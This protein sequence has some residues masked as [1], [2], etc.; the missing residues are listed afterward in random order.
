MELSLHGHRYR[1]LI[2]IALFL[3]PLQGS[4]L[5]IPAANELRPDMALVAVYVAGFVLTP[6]R[7]TL[8]GFLAGILTDILSG[9]ALGIGAFSKML[10]GLF[11]ALG[12]RLLFLNRA[13]A[14]SVMLFALSCIDGLITSLF[15]LY[16]YES[17]FFTAAMA[18]LI[19]LQAA[20]TALAGTVVII[21]ADPAIAL[22]R[23]IR[24]WLVKDLENA[25]SGI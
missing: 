19:V 2:A 24:K 20:Y 17:Y 18:R 3:V 7:A 21:A 9:A 5:D 25:V 23:K 4:L 16:F 14:H 11:A 10:A 15:L 8:L 13:L 12:R 1:W 22:M 6:F